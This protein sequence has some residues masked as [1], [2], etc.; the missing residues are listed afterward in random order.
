MTEK[1]YHVAAAQKLNPGISS[2][3][4]NV[5]GWMPTL[6]TPISRWLKET[7]VGMSRNRNLVKLPFDNRLTFRLRLIDFFNVSP[8]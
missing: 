7:P 3:L 1:N 5:E 6:T 2:N 8:L 4:K